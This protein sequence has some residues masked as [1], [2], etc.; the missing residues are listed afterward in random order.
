MSNAKQLQRYHEKAICDELVKIIT[1]GFVFERM[2]N[3]S[4]EPDVLYRSGN[5]TVGI[6]VG[7]AYYDNSDAK[8][9]WTLA[10]GERTLSGK[11]EFRR[12]G[13]LV[14]PNNVICSRI[15]EEL[16]DKCA[17]RYSG[18]DRVWLCI[19]A[20]APLGD[21]ES[22]QGCASQVSLPAH[23][24]EKIF[25]FYLSPTKITTHGSEGG[26]YKV[27]TLYGTN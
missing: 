5:E 25:L 1:S 18:T 11:Y 4:G 26:S 6:E 2:G 12:G 9:E 3:D 20:R 10:R 13:V 23:S 16:N 17:K 21:D 22:F 15:Q 14:N 19:E 8:Q 7:T 24:F 27:I